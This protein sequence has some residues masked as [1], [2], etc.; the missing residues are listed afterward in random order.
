MKTLTI[1]DFFKRKVS[2]N[3]KINISGIILPIINV[4]ENFNIPIK[5]NPNEPVEENLN[6]LIDKTYLYIKKNSTSNFKS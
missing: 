6:I 3:L 1:I 4:E 2:N 5:K